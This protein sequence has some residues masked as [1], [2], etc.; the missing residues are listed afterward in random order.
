[1]RVSPL[2]ERDSSQRDSPVWVENSAR[3]PRPG[4]IGRFLVPV[5]LVAADNSNIDDALD[6]DRRFGPG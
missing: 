4:A 1:V 5:E 2:V 6:M 3:I